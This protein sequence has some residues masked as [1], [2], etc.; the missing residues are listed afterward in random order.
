ML[1]LDTK[2][3][4]YIKLQNITQTCYIRSNFLSYV[5]ATRIPSS[6]QRNTKEREITGIEK[7]I[8]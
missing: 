4:S 8:K 3:Y 1:E 2:N 5:L 6:F 7:R